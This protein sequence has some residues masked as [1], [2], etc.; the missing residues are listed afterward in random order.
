MHHQIE[1]NTVESR[2]L[3]QVKGITNQVEADFFRAQSDNNALKRE[4]E[5]NDAN[6]AQLEKLVAMRDNQH[7]QAM[8]KESN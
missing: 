4:I 3:T 5:R 8:T 7:E 2:K 1:I 6:V